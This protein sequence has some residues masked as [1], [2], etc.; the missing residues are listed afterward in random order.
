MKDIFL[1]TK[2]LEFSL[3]NE[4]KLSDALVLWGSKKVTKYITAD[5]KMSEEQ[6]S[7]RL[8]KE[9]ENYENYHVQ[10]WP[11]YLKGSDINIGCCGLRPYELDNNIY[12]M[13]IHFN[14]NYWGQGLAQEACSAIIEYAFNILKVNA[15]FAGH[16]PNNV[17][18]SKLLKKLGFT[19]THDEFY[20]PTGLYHP[21]YL[22]SKEEYKNRKS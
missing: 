20:A 12:E 13:G 15:L 3:W 18:S 19:Y 11:V 16:N 9:M 14:E 4:E 22:L 8:K 7:E 21:S 2:R 5:G 17:A 1:E 6:I 10:Y